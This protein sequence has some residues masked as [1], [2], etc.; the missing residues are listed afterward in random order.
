MLPGSYP[1]HDLADIG[2]SLPKGNYAT[3]AGL[4]LEHL[5]EIPTAGTRLT[6]DD[7]VIEVRRVDR[8]AITEIGITCQTH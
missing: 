7:C 2:I 3:V 5:S 8:H 1:V 4:I 6:V